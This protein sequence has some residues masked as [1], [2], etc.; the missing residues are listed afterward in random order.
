MASTKKIVISKPM[1]PSKAPPPTPLEQIQK[2]FKL[3]SLSETRDLVRAGPIQDAFRQ[4]LNRYLCSHRS[5]LD[6]P[7]DWQA[8][9]AHIFA[10]RITFRDPEAHI[11]DQ[12]GR[13]PYERLPHAALFVLRVM[14]FL[15]SDGGA[16]FDGPSVRWEQKGDRDFAR[17]KRG[18]ELL[19]FLVRQHA[20]RA[21]QGP[22]KK[23]V[24]G[25][26]GGNVGI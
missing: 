15:A 25:R 1:A 6:P 21:G 10:A 8:I 26:E 3:P 20:L 19:G 5:H 9:D 23:L 12:C 22:G 16:R 18:L 4:Y 2:T 13:R 11:A 17:C 7:E 14:R 24:V